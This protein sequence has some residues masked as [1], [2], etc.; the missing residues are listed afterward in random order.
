MKDTIAILMASYN[1]ERY[2]KEQI[3]SIIN[4]DFSDWHLFISDDGSTDNTL[5]L[6][7]SYQEKFPQKIT[8]V[9]NMTKKHGSKYNFFNLV[10]IVLNEKYNYFM[11]SDQDDV[12]KKNK[13]S[14][15]FNLMKQAKNNTSVPILVHTDLEV[16]DEN[17]NTLGNSFIKYRALDPRYKDINHLLIQ[18]NVTGCTM[19][20]NRPLLVKALQFEDIDKI[21]MHDWW[22]A[23]VA[24]IYGE[25]YFLNE[26]TI[27]YRQH[28]GNVV[29]ATNVNSLAFI[30]KRVV[31]KDHVK[32]TITMSIRQAQQ[33]LISYN[34]ISQ[35]K[36]E[37]IS[38][39]VDIKR[40]NK[41]ERIK[42]VIK[43]KILKQ[44]IIQICGELLFV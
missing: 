1:G 35:E 44:G 10:N 11:F 3:E 16:V 12:W 18:N 33:L 28:G 36:K 14:D 42:F 32:D 37:L 2:I 13:V 4:Q 5:S 41:L 7:K 9:E 23:L 15:T 20:V 29:G 19:M 8:V 21:A 6:E 40:L 27:K 31:G 34:D 25:I 17:L 30:I 26:S 22:F 24:S 39:F 38:R 43:S